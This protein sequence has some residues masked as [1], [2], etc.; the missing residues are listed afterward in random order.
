MKS[1]PYPSTIS[2][3]GLGTKVSD[4]NLSLTGL[5]HTFPD[6]IDMLLVGP[7]GQQATVMSDAG[8]SATSWA[9][10]WSWTTRH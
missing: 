10:T 2:V 1:T 8:G 6:D 9:W 3:G 7:G 4:V 5:S